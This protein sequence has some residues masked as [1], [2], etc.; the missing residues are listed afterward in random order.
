[1]N[2]VA[3]NGR[4]KL[5]LVSRPLKEFEFT[6]E[7]EL[8]RKEA[9]KF[10]WAH[11]FEI[12][13][14]DAIPQII[15]HAVRHEG[16]KFDEDRLNDVKEFV[17][18]NLYILVFAILAAKEKGKPLHEIGDEDITKQVDDYI[19]GRRMPQFKS[20]HEKV[21]E[22]FSKE[23]LDP[24]EERELDDMLK[25]IALTSQFEL[26]L[27][28]ELIAELVKVKVDEVRR[29]MRPLRDSGNVVELREGN[30]RSYIIPHARLARLMS[31]VL[32][33]SEDEKVDF[34]LAYIKE[35]DYPGT[36]IKQL[37]DE[38][39]AFDYTLDLLKGKK[40]VDIPIGHL[41]IT[42][43]IAALYPLEKNDCAI[44]LTTHK[45]AILS[46][47]FIDASMEDIGKFLFD[48]ADCD[49]EFA[50]RMIQKHENEILPKVSLFRNSPIS[51]IG[52][53][54]YGIT[55][56]NEEFARKIVQSHK[57]E[58]VSKSLAQNL[59]DVGDFLSG[60]AKAD[61]N[62]AN[63]ITQ[64]HKEVIK[65]QLQTSRLDK[66]LEFWLLISAA[67]EE[68]AFETIVNLFYD[69]AIQKLQ[70]ADREQLINLARPVYFLESLG[71]KFSSFE[72][73]RIRSFTQR[74]ICH[75]KD[76]II[77]KFGSVEA[78]P[79][80]LAQTIKNCTQPPN[81]LKTDA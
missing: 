31:D 44:L 16:L 38:P 74:L 67:N 6:K 49:K 81:P 40:F 13:P 39:R 73:S 61:T 46:K 33:G 24:D 79:D 77:Q 28:E 5:L 42:E 71:W 8:V 76:I 17:R 10:D 72:K 19:R 52:W 26:P 50:K 55:E 57:K 45:E 1:M 30:R 78:M 59:D 15:Q 80:E 56:A 3:E 68:F 20:L 18:G 21:A 64:E 23:E 62:L 32:V 37:S 54:L 69:T 34:Y 7:R 53:F 29:F 47:S 27:G 11:R 35:G 75:Y 41:N 58:I 12:N 9:R 25:F 60:V 70:E 48:I 36:L 2:W 14:E 4:I 65:Q 51:N 63:E 66:W 22:S 43:I